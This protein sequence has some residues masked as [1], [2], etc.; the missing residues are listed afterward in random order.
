[1]ETE[2]G[3]AVGMY[4]PIAWANST[5]PSFGGVKCGNIIQTE[6]YTTAG[7]EPR[8]IGFLAPAT[9]SDTESFTTSDPSGIIWDCNTTG[10][11]SLRFTQHLAITNTPPVDIPAIIPWTQFYLNLDMSGSAPQSGAAEVRPKNLP[12]AEFKYS[13]YTAAS[14]A[15]GVL[16][17]S[18]VTPEG[19]LTSTVIPGG[20]WIYSIYAST[21]DTTEQNKLYANLYY[22]DADGVSNPVLIADG[23]SNAQTLTSNLGDPYNYIWASAFIPSSFVPDLTKRLQ[24]RIYIDFGA[25]S[26]ASVYS[27]GIY[28]ANVMTNIQTT[29]PPT[30]V[31]DTVNMRMTIASPTSEFNQVLET[32]IPVVKDPLDLDALVYTGSVSGIV[33]VDAGSSLICEIV[34]ETGTTQVVS[35]FAFLPSP[36][37]NL[38]WNLIAQGSYGN[39]G[40]IV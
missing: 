24:M 29:L 1:M 36:T 32:S 38:Q 28:T 12:P 34:S 20:A 37:C 21:T 39:V 15:G 14:P 3:P 30:L 17:A 8:T 18:F 26:D 19:F 23:V 2:G 9:W 6:Q 27:E 40:L 25:A 31:R 7:L 33:N 35:G 22:V 11:Y 16:M 13:S 10:I 5:T 4:P